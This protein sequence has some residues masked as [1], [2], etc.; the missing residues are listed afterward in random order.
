MAPP[1]YHQY[2]MPMM[3]NTYTKALEES[4]IP[5]QHFNGQL[6]DYD[7]W[8]EKLQQWLGGCDPTYRKANEVCMTLSTLPPWLRRIIN[9]RV[10]E[11]PQHTRTPPTLKELWDFLEQHLHEYDPSRADERWRALT[12][13]MVKGHVTLTDLE[14][15]YARWRLLLPLTNETRPHVIWQQ[16]LSKLAWIKEK[17][18]KQ[19]AKNSQDSYVVDFSGLDPSPGRA[20]FENE[21]RK[22]SA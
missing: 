17:V 18:V 13:G 5:K 7:E 1:A 2:Q 19:G 21:L 16:L 22:Y 6:E 10:A 12:P 8:V 14:D 15:F 20:L 4:D 11:A 9:T 3:Q